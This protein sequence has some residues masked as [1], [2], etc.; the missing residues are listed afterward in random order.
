MIDL[1]EIYRYR[2]AY[3]EGHFLLASGRHSPVFLQ[4]AAVLQYP[5]EAIKIG[6]ALAQLFSEPV[7][8]VIGPAIGGVTLAFA[9][10]WA[11]QARA[12]FAEK[13]PGGGFLIRPGFRLEAGEPF[14]AVE[15][16]VTSGSSVLAALNAAAAAGA[17]PLGV[18][19]IFDRSGGKFRPPVA[20]KALAR[21]E[22][23]VYPAEAC[24]LCAAGVPLSKV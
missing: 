2:G 1:L 3:L 18:A 23:P 17:T 5:E 4:S 13:A 11:K 19:T 15:D 20:F 22:A 12:I 24:P 9:T 16:V 6:Q 7:G 8:F 14:L 21:L 10:A